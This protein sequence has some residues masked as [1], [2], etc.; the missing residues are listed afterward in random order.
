FVMTTFWIISIGAS[1]YLA[2]WA[3][4]PIIENYER[5]KAFVE[6]ASHELRTPL[7]VLQN[8]LETLFRKP[9]ATILENSENIASSLDEVRN[10]RIL[11]TNLL[12]LARRDDGIKPE[13][14]VIKPTLF[15]SIFEN[16]DLIAQEN[17]KNFTGH[18]MIQDSFKTD[19]TLLKQL[20]T[21][22]FDNAIKYTDNDGS[23]DFTI[24]ETDKYLFLE[25]ADN[26]PGISEE[27]KVRIFD[28]FYRVDKAR[29][30]QQGG[31]GLGL[32]LA[33]QI[34]NSL[35]GNITVIDN[36]PRGSIFKIKLPKVKG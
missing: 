28:R 9:N 29:T 33:Q 25:I 8:R 30:R 26:G 12:N 23:I 21:I 22:L 3:Q 13:L 36:K 16:Y 2:K 11:T 1:I 34:V 27:D 14:A 20:M 17:G 32:S 15:D 19:K 31:F 6:N 18:N 5:Q 7:A 10:M 4:K 35:R 24:S